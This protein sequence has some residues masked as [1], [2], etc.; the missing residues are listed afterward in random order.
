[1]FIKPQDWEGCK[2]FSIMSSFEHL[3]KESGLNE[4]ASWLRRLKK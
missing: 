1:M 3:M 2:D 4:R